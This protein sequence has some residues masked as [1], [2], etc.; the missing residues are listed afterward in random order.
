MC[1]VTCKA[2]SA[3]IPRS[4]W[5]GRSSEVRPECFHK[6]FCCIV[7]LLL[8]LFGDGVLSC[9]PGYSGFRFLN[10]GILGVCQHA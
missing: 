8:Q 4:L 5:D 1:P 9:S 6:S 7:I 10:S 3:P 2:T